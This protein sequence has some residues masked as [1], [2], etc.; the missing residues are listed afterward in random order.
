MP[1]LPA[2][3][4]ELAQADY[5][6]GKGHLKSENLA[7]AASAFHNALIGFEKAEDATGI[8]KAS[9][10]L[11]DI[12]GRKGEHRAAIAYYQRA[13]TIC[14]HSGDTAGLLSLRG[15]LADCYRRAGER[16]QAITIYLDMLDTYCKVFDPGGAIDVLTTLAAIYEEA[17]ER[18]KV[19]DAYRTAASIQAN[20]GNTAKAEELLRKASLFAG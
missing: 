20:F 7:Q 2:E 16:D 19:A 11:G 14:E 1:E 18:S 9:D 17:G 3:E 15:K 4:L 5:K 6:A 10:K 8:A 13:F 12:C